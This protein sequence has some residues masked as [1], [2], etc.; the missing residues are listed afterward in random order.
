MGAGDPQGD[1]ARGL[2]THGLFIWMGAANPRD[3]PKR[4]LYVTPVTPVG[5]LGRGQVPL[6]AKLVDSGLLLK[7]PFDAQLLLGAT[8]LVV[9]DDIRVSRDE[10]DARSVVDG[11]LCA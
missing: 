9:E 7:D 10:L 6:R 4:H 1:L 11:G 2:V 8:F 3:A 5:Y